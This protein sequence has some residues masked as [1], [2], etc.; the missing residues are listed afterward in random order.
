M[1]KRNKYVI[2]GIFLILGFLILNKT[3]SELKPIPKVTFKSQ[4]LNYDKSE[5]GSF[6]IDKSA[7]WIGDK[8]AK[9]TLEV[10]SIAKE[11]NKNKDVIFAFDVSSTMDNT[12]LNKI[13]KD[14]K[15]LGTTILGDSKNRVAIITF[16]TNAKKLLDFTSNKNDFNQQ[17]DSLNSKGATNYKAGLDE[18]KKILESYKKEE[19]KELT[20]LLLTDGYP[21][22]D[23]P[24]EVA[25]YKE[26]KHK[27][28]FININAIQY[29]MGDDI[30]KE[31]KAI[32]DR[33]Y[34]A[35][36]DKN[37]L[38][39]AERNTQVYDNFII[40][41]YISN[42]FKGVP[43]KLKVTKGN[44]KLENNRILW[45]L[46]Q[47]MTG[48]K[49]K[50]EIEL[51]LV[52]KN[53]N[54]YKINKGIDIKTSLE[55]KEDKQKSD[56]TPILKGLYKVIY[57]ANTPQGC[58][59]E[60]LAKTANYIPYEKVEIDG[61]NPK[62]NGYLFKGYKLVS[63]VKELNEDYIE[64]PEKDVYLKATWAKIKVTKN[65]NG[66]ETPK[67][68]LYNAVKDSSLGNDKQLGIDLSSPSRGENGEG[69]YQFD[70]SKND[71][72][73]IYY[74]R[75]S[76][77]VNN[78][79][80]YGGFCWR[81]VRTTETGGV[82]AIYNGTPEKGTCKVNL[83]I[84][85]RFGSEEQNASNLDLNS[86][87]KPMAQSRSL[88][89]DLPIV[90]TGQFNPQNNHRKYVGYMYGSDEKPYENINN[91]SIKEDVDKWYELNIKDKKFEKFLDKKSIYCG[92][93][94]EIEP[95]YS[96]ED[97]NGPDRYHYMGIISLYPA[98]NY[99]DS[100]NRHK[101]FKLN[102]KCPVN[103][104]YSVEGG[105]KKLTYPISLLS[106]EDVVLAGNLN[107]RHMK[108]RANQMG[109][110]EADFDENYLVINNPY[111]ILSPG[112]INRPI[113]LKR[114]QDN[115][116]KYKLMPQGYPRKEERERGINLILIEYGVMP[117]E[118]YGGMPHDFVG[119]RPVITISNPTLLLGGNGS[120][121][122]PYIV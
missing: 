23:T 49:A 39:D 62:C 78:N 20:V 36:I 114:S 87:L 21:G 66:K 38:I 85:G 63:N 25:I 35:S 116:I 101:P 122:D 106:F 45:N 103:D 80:I 60:N 52:D 119:I 93:R 100:I 43:S 112:L 105:N 68:T 46:G 70:E 32:S 92:D 26:L 31:V 64:M 29:D 76:H 4:N 55:G 30:K 88:F 67:Y 89:T 24:N 54:F 102:M 91:S 9:I 34:L 42:Y 27:Y 40:T 115:K 95:N 51:E 104:S 99:L 50:L 110:E 86:M 13:K 83:Y 84:R 48:D 108:Q 96:D 6:K 109:N 107:G 1:K 11:Q 41:D 59:V 111:W 75:G 71:N 8:K 15:E 53:K 18:V 90:G 57:E 98:A 58:T 69:V 82:K 3:L 19:G 10:N 94:T 22:K 65:Q 77:R 44:A 56:E 61:S 72:Y 2:L 7:K 28:P 113:L 12:K 79:V 47:Y 74:Y 121:S 73:P 33:Q 117:A 37:I 17:I 120:L 16:D 5:P 81:I 97:F 118:R 14:A